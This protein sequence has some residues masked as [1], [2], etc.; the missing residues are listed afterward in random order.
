MDSCS[1]DK[2]NLCTVFEVSPTADAVDAAS[3]NTMA[4]DRMSISQF[5]AQKA[6]REREE[7]LTVTECERC[8]E[9]IPP[10]RKAAMPY[11]RYCVHCQ[12]IIDKE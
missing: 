3:D 9:E 4:F 8:G 6:N 1:C 5:Q 2:T 12:E 10:K 7:Y 11:T